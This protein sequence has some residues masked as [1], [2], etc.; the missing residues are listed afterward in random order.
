MTLLNRV[1][2]TWTTLQ[3]KRGLTRPSRVSRLLQGILT[4]PT[5]TLSWRLNLG[6]SPWSVRAEGA[7]S[8]STASL[9][10]GTCRSLGKE[11]VKFPGVQKSLPLVGEELWLSP[12]NSPTTWTFRKLQLRR[13]SL[14]VPLGR[15]V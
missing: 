12:E 15:V 5:W 11:L 14:I 8:A 6:S 9:A 3:A 13:H 2:L 10:L 1:I 7:L 4:S